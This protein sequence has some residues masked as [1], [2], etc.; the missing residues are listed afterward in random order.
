MDGKVNISHRA[1]ERQGADIGRPI[2]NLLASCQQDD[3]SS[4]WN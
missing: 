1:E 3:D 4:R 2:R